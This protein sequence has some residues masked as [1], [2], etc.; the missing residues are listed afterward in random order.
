MAHRPHVLGRRAGPF[1]ALVA[2]MAQ[3]PFVR[4]ASAGVGRCGRRGGGLSKLLG[5]GDGGEGR[6]S[7]DG[8]EADAASLFI[9]ANPPNT[10][11]LQSLSR[12]A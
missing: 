6:E 10:V 4:P 11:G 12:A 9:I 1:P 7:D 8:A 5:L 2:A 3:V